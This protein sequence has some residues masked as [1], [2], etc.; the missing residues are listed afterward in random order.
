[1]KTT[2]FERIKN[3]NGGKNLIRRQIRKQPQNIVGQVLLVWPNAKNAKTEI[4]TWNCFIAND[5]LDLTLLYTNKYMN[6][7][8]SWLS[9]ERDAK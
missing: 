6:S 3:Q 7:I 4:E 8:S 2:F 5:I 9:Q 1:M